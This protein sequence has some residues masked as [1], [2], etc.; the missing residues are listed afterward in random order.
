[1]SDQMLYLGCLYLFGAVEFSSA[2]REE[3]VVGGGSGELNVCAEG[4]ECAVN[5][6]EVGGEF[7]V[8][9]VGV[10]GVLGVLDD[11]ERHGNASTVL[12]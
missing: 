4:T 5:V 2:V 6:D 11:G 9:G 1:M 8:S 3:V 12:Q 7:V 10:W